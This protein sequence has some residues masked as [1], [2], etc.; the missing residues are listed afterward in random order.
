MSKKCPVQLGG[1]LRAHR[2]LRRAINRFLL[3]AGLSFLAAARRAP[4]PVSRDSPRCSAKNRAPENT[5]TTIIAFVNIRISSLARRSYI[6]LSFQEIS[7][8]GT[9]RQ[10]NLDNFTTT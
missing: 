10:I 2:H 6:K 3:T 4:Y 7:L 5:V 1:I 9:R 8:L